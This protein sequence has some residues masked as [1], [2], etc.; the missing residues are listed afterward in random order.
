[1]N[2][3]KIYEL[4]K[5]KCSGLNIQPVKEHMYRHIF[6]TRFNLHFKIPRKDTCKQYD[7]YKI[8]ID[9]SD[10]QETIKK[11]KDEHEL[12]LLKVEEACKSM[13]EDAAKCST[14]IDN[15]YVC[16]MDLQKALPFPKLNVSD[17]YY[18]R[19]MDCYNFGIHD[20][21]ENI[22]YFYVWDETIASKGVHR[23]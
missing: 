2:I 21:R 7:E 13:K 6:N 4:Y 17:A 15:I 18:K 10:D 16:S 20:L 1:M 14:T 3:W 22:G 9:A 11:L 19:N 8:K 5:E 23:K 12:H